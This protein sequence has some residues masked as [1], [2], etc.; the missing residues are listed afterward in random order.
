MSMSVC[1][2]VYKKWVKLYKYPI[3]CETL[4]KWGFVP[5]FVVP[6]IRTTYIISKKKNPLFDL[7]LKES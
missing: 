5:I 2:C 4:R 7:F 6:F 1:A 3:D